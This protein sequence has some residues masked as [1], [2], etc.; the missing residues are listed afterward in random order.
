[1]CWA[2]QSWPV[3]RTNGHNL[4]LMQ[5]FCG[6]RAKPLTT[7][8]CCFSTDFTDHPTSPG[9]LSGELGQY[10]LPSTNFFCLKMDAYV[11]HLWWKNKVHKINLLPQISPLL[12]CYPNIR[13]GHHAHHSSRPSQTGL[14]PFAVGAPLAPP[15]PIFLSSS[16]S[17]TLL[18]LF[19]LE[20]HV[21]NITAL[22]KVS[23]AF[24][25]LLLNLKKN[26]LAQYSKPITLFLELLI[27]LLFTHLFVNLLLHTGQ[28]TAAWTQEARCFF[29]P[30]PTMVP[31]M[32]DLP[33]WTWVH[34]IHIS[35]ANANSNLL[36]FHRKKL[37]FL[38][39][40][41]DGRRFASFMKHLTYTEFNYILAYV[42]FAGICSYNSLKNNKKTEGLLYI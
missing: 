37:S 39:P 6:V 28:F 19:L 24:S 7:G 4:D 11:T 29:L 30:L 35:K 32:S 2:Q 33:S 22:G 15:P 27:L 17:C 13:E 10:F 16:Q 5:R 31:R 42:P 8:L 18:T 3:T 34:S 23:L 25:S 38:H 9:S 21:E 1:M 12:C 26:S 20:H 41:C 36:T 40:Y 14:R